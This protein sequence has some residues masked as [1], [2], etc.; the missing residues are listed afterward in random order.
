MDPQTAAIVQ[1]LSGGTGSAGSLSPFGP[2]QAAANQQAYIMPQ[3][4]SAQ[5]QAPAAGM[6]PPPG[7]GQN[8]S[9]GDMGGLS[10]GAAPQSMYPAMMQQPPATNYWA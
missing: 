9:M 1:A 10:L 8:A 6:Q 4:P 5:Q 3:D 7:A 2:Q